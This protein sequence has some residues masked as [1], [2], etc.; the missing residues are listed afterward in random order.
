M[1]AALLFSLILI[2]IFSGAASAQ[3]ASVD[4]EL[5]KGR[6]RFIAD[7]GEVG[8]YAEK[9]CPGLAGAQVYTVA[10]PSR[11]SLSLRWRG[12]KSADIV[13]SWS[14]GTKLEWRGIGRKNALKPYAAIV[15]AIVRDLETDQNHKV[16]AV[17]RIEPRK[18]CLAAAIDVDANKDAIALARQTA[19]TETRTFICGSDQPR[20]VGAPSAWAQQV[21]GYDGKASK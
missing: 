19:D 8:D 14:L 7:D 10:R 1:R 2:A 9:R 5:A 6:C 12:N 13:Q 20:L 4:T 18:A 16:I 3:P 17:L 15:T 11:V 21:T